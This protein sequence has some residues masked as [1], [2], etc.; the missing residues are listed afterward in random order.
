MG[1]IVAPD[2]FESRRCEDWRN[3]LTCL[4]F[5]VSASITASY[6]V[7]YD[8]L[9]GPILN[10]LICSKEKVGAH[11]NIQ[12]QMSAGGKPVAG[13]KTTTG[14]LKFQQIFWADFI[15]LFSVRYIQ[16]SLARQISH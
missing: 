11:L 9:N 6:R 8:I 3:P 7:L 13:R 1:L 15:Q 16:L 2:I 14:R 12:G 4:L 10:H 5:A